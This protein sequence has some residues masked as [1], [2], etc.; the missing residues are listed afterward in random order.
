M[1]VRV[2]EYH[3]YNL[4]FVFD[5]VINAEDFDSYKAKLEADNTEDHYIQ[6]CEQL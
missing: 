3:M 5:E 4:T 2:Y 6:V 1:T